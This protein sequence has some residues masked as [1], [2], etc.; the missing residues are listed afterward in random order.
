MESAQPSPA[1]AT[2]PAA[3]NSIASLLYHDGPAHEADNHGLIDYLQS[4]GDYANDI[5][6][7]H[8]QP[9][10][11]HG[12]RSP[13]PPNPSIPIPSSLNRL[14]NTALAHYVPPAI[15]P[16]PGAIDEAVDYGDRGEMGGKRRKLPHQRAGWADMEN[17]QSK[18]RRTRK[19]EDAP[20]LVGSNAG[21]SASP[22][23]SQRASAGVQ[24]EVHMPAGQDLSSLT[25][26]SR[27]ALEGVTGETLQNQEVQD[28][29]PQQGTH[30]ID[31]T[32]ASVHEPRPAPPEPPVSN[33]KLSRAE[34]NKRAQQAFRRRREEHMKKLEAESAQLQVV[35][36]QCQEKDLIIKDLVLGQQTDKIR[37]AALE[38][39]I[40]HLAPH[41]NI[42]FLPPRASLTFPK[43][44]LLLLV[45]L[46]TILWLTLAR[47]GVTLI[48]RGPLMFLK[49]RV[50]R[51][52]R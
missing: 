6:H 26:L 12:Q 33:E 47:E 34:Q 29:K 24:G 19:S 28:P 20:H 48:L 27:M 2:N 36:K 8:A 32:L 38:S 51:L 17:S 21:G 42:P 11:G 35:L 45:P 43:T 16:L 18:K 44:L 4:H 7:Y 37:I 50:G 3:A 9:S 22:A 25:E 31:P 49:G 14:A 5:N 13:S 1:S 46:E 30:E 23:A 41:V 52:Q 40:K 15:P 39:L 10:H